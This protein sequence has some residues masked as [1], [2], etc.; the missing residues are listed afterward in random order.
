MTIAVF[1]EDFKRVND[2]VKATATRRHRALSL[3]GTATIIIATTIT[4]T[5]KV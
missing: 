2:S 3:D 5:A 4:I 1:I